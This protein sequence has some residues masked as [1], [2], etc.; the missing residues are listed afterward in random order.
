MFVYRTGSYAFLHSNSKL[1]GALVS[2]LIIATGLLVLG[3]CD[4]L[5]RSFVAV[6][7]SRLG[8]DRAGPLLSLFCLPGLSPMAEAHS[9]FQQCLMHA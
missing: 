3:D 4:W 9:H 5:A 8:C 2:F 6:L 1:H 7:E